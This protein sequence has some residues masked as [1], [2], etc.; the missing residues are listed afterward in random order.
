M[1]LSLDHLFRIMNVPQEI[2]RDAK[3]FISII[4]YGVIMIVFF[5][6][7][8]GFMRAL[9][10]SKTPLYF[11]IFTTLLNISFNILFIYWFRLG[12]KA[13]GSRHRLRHDGF[14]HLLFILHRQ[15]FPLLHPKAEDWKLNW[16]FSKQHP[17]NRRTDGRPVFHHCHQR[18]H[19]AKRLQLFRPRYHCRFHFGDAGR[20]AGNSADGLFRRCNGDLCGTKLR[21]RHDRPHPPRRFR[22]FDDLPCP[23]PFSGCRHV[24]FR[25]PHHRGI[26]VSDEHHNVI[27]IAQ[28]YLNISI[29]FYFFSRPDIYF[30]QLFAGNGQRRHTDG[31]KH[32]RTRHAGFCRHL[33]GRPAS[34][35]SAFVMPAR[36]R[37]SADLPSSVSAT[38]GLSAVPDSVTFTGE[39]LT[40]TPAAAYKRPRCQNQ[41]DSQRQQTNQQRAFVNQNIAQQKLNVLIIVFI[42]VFQIMRHNLTDAVF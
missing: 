33:P 17:Q 29:L 21:R 11:L 7:L 32:C 30:P 18:R 40:L 3:D 34:D 36:L 5:N 1:L 20:T 38:S 27:E 8:S 13:I 39:R 25:N 24:P 35:M 14:G 26:F 42:I 12:V 4:S 22:M 10:D 31:L 19:Y 37:G 6:L 15:K 16:Q 41:P 9:G 28:T 23:Q 2:I